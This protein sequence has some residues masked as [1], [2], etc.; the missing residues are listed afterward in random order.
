MK[1]ATQTI[2]VSKLILDYDFYPREQIQ[3]YHVNELVQALDAGV[4]LPPIVVDKKTK[5]VVDGFHR[6]RAYQRFYGADAE[7]PAT[8]K[9]YESE[10][11]M[12]LEAMAFNSAHGR[13]LSTYDKARCIARAEELELQPEVV[14]KALNTTVER[15]TELRAERIAFYEK[16]PVVLKRTAIHLAGTELEKEQLEY[17]VRAGGMQQT[18]YINQVIAMLEADAVDWDDEK[19]VKAL[20]RL[21]GLLDKALKLVEV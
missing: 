17:N 18:F 11:T 14:A 9:E 13:P 4:V 12:Y 19:T 3:S 8:L 5:R 16:K 7:I 2:K 15:I 20:K 10:A 1:G 21:H 6:V